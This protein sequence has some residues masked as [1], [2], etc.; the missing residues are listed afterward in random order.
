MMYYIL[1]E[2]VPLITIQREMDKSLG[3]VF[4]YVVVR[5]WNLPRQSS[6]VTLK[7]KKD[8]KVTVGGTNF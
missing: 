1:L 5:V 4:E 2:L 8:F 3:I 7:K 6:S